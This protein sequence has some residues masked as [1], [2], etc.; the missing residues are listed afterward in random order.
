MLHSRG[1]LKARGLPLSNLTPAAGERHDEG[2]MAAIDRTLCTAAG[3]TV[4]TSSMWQ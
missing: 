3:W 4:Q 1:H 2:N